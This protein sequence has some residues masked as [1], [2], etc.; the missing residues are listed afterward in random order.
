MDTLYLQKKAYMIAIF[1]LIVGAL[2]WLLVGVA[3]IDLVKLLLGTGTVARGIYILIGLCAL[4][5]AFNRDTYL[6]FLGPTVIPCGAIQEHTPPGATTQM[7]VSVQ[8]DAKVLYWAAEPETEHLKNL[9]DWRQAYLKFEN[10]GVV[11]A[12]SSGIATLKVRRPQAYLVPWKGR[13]EP[14]IHFRVCG[15]GGFLGRV[16]TVFLADGHVEGFMI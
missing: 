6:P 5:I 4:L 3:K 16:K 10:A 14:H 2:N 15:Q 11:L 9:K 1:L 7:Q 8:P 13:L 12:D